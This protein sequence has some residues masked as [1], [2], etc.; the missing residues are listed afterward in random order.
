MKL[1][2]KD[3]KRASE[4]EHEGVGLWAIALLFN[5]HEQTMR[6]YLRNYETYGESYWTP[7]PEEV[8]DEG[9]SW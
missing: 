9:P 3:V 1:S 8:I 5:V 6:R 2:Y 4:M 7:Y